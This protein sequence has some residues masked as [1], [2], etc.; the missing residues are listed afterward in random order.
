MFLPVTRARNPELIEAAFALH[1]TGVVPPD[2]YLIDLDQVAQNASALAAEADRLGLTLWFVVKQ[3]GR[4]PLVTAAVARSI[5]RAAAIDG[6]EAERLTA[7]GAELG[8]V[9]HIVQIPVRE[10]D[11]VLARR[12]SVI[13]VYDEE[14]L[15]AVGAAA[16]RAGM[17]QDILL[18]IAGAPEDVYPGQEGGFHPDEVQA[19][20]RLAADVPGV[21]VA[22]V[23]GFACVLY[24]EAEQRPAPTATLARVIAAADVLRAEGLEQPIVNLPSLS[25]VATLPELARLGATHAEPGHALTGTTPYHAV[26]E[27]LAEIPSMVYLT[28][29]AHQ[30]A[31]GP[32]VF[33]GGFY[34][35]ARALN[36]IV[37]TDAGD[38]PASV[39]EEPAEFIDYYRRIDPAGPV[40]VGDGVVMAFRTQIFV[41]RSLVAVVS[42]L[43]TD[44]P[45]LEGF[46]DA[47]GRPVRPEEVRVG[48]GDLPLP[49]GWRLGDAL[50]AS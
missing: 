35:R 47:N 28:E 1:A 25:S 17:V 5:P 20:H 48:S 21:R 14:N 7:G 30:D 34:D 2:T 29:I 13:T 6:R 32:S 22:G 46:F 26:N 41:T 8:N 49:A 3:I 27:N 42:G 36:A 50:S 37:R 24:S 40:H 18:R 38:V 9:G 45:V 33:G 16:V 31:I 4:N 12:P 11:G 43:R 23:T 15:R 44:A 19:I 39:F 10:L